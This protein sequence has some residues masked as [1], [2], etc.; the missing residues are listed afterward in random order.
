MILSIITMG[1]LITITGIILPITILT[2][3][4][5]EITGM[6]IAITTITPIGVAIT[7]DIMMD[8]TNQAIT[9]ILSET[10]T[11]I[12]AHGQ[13]WEATYQTILFKEGITPI[14]KPP[15]KTLVEIQ[16]QTYLQMEVLQILLIV[17]ILVLG[18]LQIPMLQIPT[19]LQ[20]MI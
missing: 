5:M 15:T 12:M 10:R 13:T 16:Q 19:D 2:I 14:L 1:I 11:I 7:M 3:I 20:V 8:T 6:E 18:I 4:G 17:S 9:Q